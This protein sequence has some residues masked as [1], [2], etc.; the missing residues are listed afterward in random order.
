MNPRLQGVYV[1]LDGGAMRDLHSVL[2]A[3]LRAGIR[4]FQYRE[5]RGPDRDVLI[6]LHQKTQVAGAVL[7]VNDAVELA[8]LA[9]GVHLGQEDARRYILSDLRR[10]LPHGIIGLSAHTPDQ[11][12]A[13]VCVDYLGVG[14]YK[15]TT[16]KETDRSPLGIE[17]LRK[18]IH[19]TSL[20]ICAI[21]GVK[22]AD[23]A[24]LR[25]AGVA[26]AAVIGAIAASSDT[27]AAATSLQEAWDAAA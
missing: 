8:H 25:N 24:A 18:I 14:P 19:V 1:L 27:Y 22:A 7:L 23:L 6:S 12:R 16:S 4:L 2:D 5:K 20:P 10:S 15:A 9:D 3:A 11:A 21:G 13:A 26:M 17:G